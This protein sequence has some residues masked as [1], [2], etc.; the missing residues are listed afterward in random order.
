MNRL[1][2]LTC[3]LNALWASV[4]FAQRPQPPI[5]PV[6]NPDNGHYYQLVIDLPPDRP[7]LPRPFL[8][9][10]ALNRSASTTHLGIPGHLVTITSLAEQAF[11]EREFAGFYVRD[12]LWI[13]ASDAAVEGEWRWV[14]GPEAGQL[15]WLGDETGT[16]LGFHSWPSIGS[17]RFSEPNNFRSRFND[18]QH[19]NYA[20]MFL[21][22][23]EQ[24]WSE[25]G[26][27]NLWY[28]LAANDDHPWGYVIE[29]SPIPEPAASVLT[30]LACLTGVG[31]AR[32]RHN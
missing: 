4:A 15:F 28:D 27:N 16:A 5:D 31:W 20:A 9:E 19:E 26:K 21:Y 24:W 25:A 29:F 14:A 30:A 3:A 22:R 2:F 23:P 11:L 7:R 32:R 6:F 10:D 12:F 13:A 1:L 8:F 18:Y 17:G